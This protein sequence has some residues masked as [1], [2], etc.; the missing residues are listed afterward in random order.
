ML[1]LSKLDSPNQAAMAEFRG[2]GPSGNLS[3]DDQSVRETFFH[4]PLDVKHVRFNCQAKAAWLPIFTCGV[5]LHAGPPQWQYK[6]EIGFIL[7]T[8]YIDFNLAF[9]NTQADLSFQTSDSNGGYCHW[10]SKLI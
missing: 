3:T 6:T 9:S 8:T 2:P 10:D 7:G 1:D 4:F 5:R